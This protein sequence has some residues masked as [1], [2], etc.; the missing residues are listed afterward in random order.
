MRELEKFQK[1]V[2]A[3]S[4]APCSRECKRAVVS[5]SQSVLLFV[6]GNKNNTKSKGVVAVVKIVIV[7]IR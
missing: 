7:H 3:T 6:C 5:Y 4:F 1:R 2:P